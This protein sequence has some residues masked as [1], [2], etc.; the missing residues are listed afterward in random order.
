M[1]HPQQGTWLAIYDLHYPQYNIP[2]WH[3]ALDFIQQNPHIRGFIFGGD[4]FDNA[5]ISHHNRKKPLYKEESLYIRNENGFMRD[6]LQPLY[7]LLPRQARKIYIIGNHD[8]WEREFIEEHPE[9]SG[10]VDRV[11]SLN[12][13]AAGWQIIPLGHAYKLGKLNVIHGEVL[14]GTIPGIYPAK[15]AVE[16]YGANVLAG[17][18]HSPQSFAKVSPV[19][20]R[21]KWMAWI[22]PCA[23]NLNPA[24]I[25]SRPHAWICGLTIIEVHNTGNFNLY[26]I[27]L[28]Q[29]GT[30]TYGGKE[31][32]R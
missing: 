7:Q 17:H 30:F 25:R 4:Q 22:A 8:Y 10:L 2:T 5:E 24:Y 12:L 9:L 19:E 15:K 3:C 23:C 1:N 11:R 32:G 13:Q 28:S 16:I 6:I 20:L 26:P 31:Y 27:I 14:T 21:Q 29:N 18:T